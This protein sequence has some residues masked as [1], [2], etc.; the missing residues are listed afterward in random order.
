MRILSIEAWRYDGIWNWNQWWHV[1]DM[2]KEDF[3]KIESSNRKILAWMREEGLLSEASKGKVAVEDDESNIV[4][5]K[6]STREPIFAIEYGPE[7]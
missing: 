4:I 2:W 5:L 6:K 1:G 7:Y 3:E